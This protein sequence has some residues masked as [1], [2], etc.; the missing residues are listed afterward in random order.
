MDKSKSDIVR[1]IRDLKLI[2]IRNINAKHKID[3]ACDRLEQIANEL[4]VNS[5]IE[6][7]A[8]KAEEPKSY[9]W[10]PFV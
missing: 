4:E 8:P 7:E 10:W 3:C 2:P 9:S 5:Y 1:V 6:I